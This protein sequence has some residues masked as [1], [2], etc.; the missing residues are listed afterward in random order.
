MALLTEKYRIKIA[1]RFVGD[2]RGWKSDQTG[3]WLITAFKD[4]AVDPDD[5]SI[6]L[7]HPVTGEKRLVGTTGLGKDGG[8]FPFALNNGDVGLLV[9]EAPAPG[10]SGNLADA[11]LVV[12]TYNIGPEV[13][14]PV[15][16][17]ASRNLIAALTSRV[18]AGETTNTAQNVRLDNLTA[19]VAGLE[20]ADVLDGQ[21]HTALQAQVN[22]LLTRVTA[23]EG[24]PAGA[25]TDQVARDGV[26]AINTR[27]AKVKA[28]L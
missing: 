7:V 9:T 8:V 3:E 24:R 18:T 1:N 26:A 19:R 21:R 6:Y 22:N 2:I 10:D 25:G 15:V 12:T 23:L 13:V 17:Q 11:Y 20:R 4:P 5:T 16:D 14:A 27:L 28:D